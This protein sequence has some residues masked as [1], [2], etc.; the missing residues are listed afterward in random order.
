MLSNA[1]EPAGGSVFY[2]SDLWIAQPFETGNISDGY[3]LNLCLVLGGAFSSSLSIYS[4]NNGTPANSLGLG[5]IALSASTTYWIVA[6]AS[7]PAQTSGL[8]SSSWSY[9]SDNNY[10]S[11]SDNWSINPTFD[12]STDGSNWTSYATHSPFQFTI[13]S[14]PVPEPSTCSLAGLGLA[15]IF[16][17]GKSRIFPIS[18]VAKKLTRQYLHSKVPASP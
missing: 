11:S 13:T 15:I 1:G 4:D 6:T 9:A 3:T 5:G 2:G 12:L 16:I 10:S 14:T 17:C 7:T 18:S 8:F